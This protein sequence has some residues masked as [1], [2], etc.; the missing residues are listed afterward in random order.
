MGENEDADPIA[1]RSPA[2]ALNKEDLGNEVPVDMITD[3]NIQS[4][5]VD[6]E[7][8]RKKHTKRTEANSS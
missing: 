3:G 1:K 5:T 6:V 7:K 4:E 2:D 8:E